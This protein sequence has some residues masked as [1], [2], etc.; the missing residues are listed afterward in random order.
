MSTLNVLLKYRVPCADEDPANEIRM[1]APHGKVPEN[2]RGKGWKWIF[3]AQLP[4]G[5]I[6][7]YEAGIV[8][9]A[10]KETAL[11]F[12]HSELMS[13]IEDVPYLKDAEVVIINVTM[14]HIGN[15]NGFPRLQTCIHA[16]FEFKDG[17]PVK[18]LPNENA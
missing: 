8:M 6:N 18:E 2:K 1:T 15:G 11:A 12:D 16:A 10:R 3:K 9:A 13:A 17:K 14:D 7:E 5:F 4:R